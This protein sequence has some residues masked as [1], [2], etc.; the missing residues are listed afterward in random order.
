MVKESQFH[1]GQ[2]TETRVMNSR[3]IVY[4][5]AIGEVVETTEV[6]GIQVDIIRH[7]KVVQE[8]LTGSPVLIDKDADYE[9]ARAG[10]YTLLAP[11][12][13]FRTEGPKAGT[14]S[15]SVGSRIDNHKASLGQSGTIAGAKA[16]ARRNLETQ[17]LLDTFGAKAIREV[18]I[19]GLSAF[20][21]L[22]QAA[23]IHVG[24]IVAARGHGQFR[25]AVAVKVTATKI[26]YLF[27]TPSSN[28]CLTFGTG[29]PGAEVRLI[30]REARK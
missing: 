28:G 5:H 13:T 1:S 10:Q 11:E 24:D 4:Q 26:R 15:S 25:R 17:V 30:R 14:W 7:R 6:A 12:I 20:R 3:T 2:Q 22:D 9:A 8:T 16:A 27:T 21:E 18:G 23:G 29:T 19:I